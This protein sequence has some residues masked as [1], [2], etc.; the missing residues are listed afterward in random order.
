MPVPVDVGAD[1]PWWYQGETGPATLSAIGNVWVQDPLLG[2]D[3]AFGR[4]ILHGVLP[5]AD[6]HTFPAFRAYWLYT[7]VDDVT[8]VLPPP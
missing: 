2:Y 4:Y 6:D 3:C 8:L 1:E 5:T 7:F